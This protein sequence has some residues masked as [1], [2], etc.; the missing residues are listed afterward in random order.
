[1]KSLYIRSAKCK[2]LSRL[3]VICKSPI[4][5]VSVEGGVFQRK[6]FAVSKMQLNLTTRDSRCSTFLMPGKFK[7][8]T[9]LNNCLSCNSRCR[10]FCPFVLLSNIQI[11]IVNLYFKCKS[12]LVSSYLNCRLYF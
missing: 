5:D 2:H 1:M 8:K 9:S 10:L 7:F 3:N 6:V 11:C 4:L 12:L